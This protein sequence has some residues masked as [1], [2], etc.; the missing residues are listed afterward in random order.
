MTCGSSLAELGR[1]RLATPTEGN[2]Y[3]DVIATEE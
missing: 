1:D 2:R 3:S